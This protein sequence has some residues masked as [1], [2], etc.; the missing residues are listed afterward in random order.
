MVGEDGD[1]D[2]VVSEDSPPAPHLGSLVAVEEGAPPTEVPFQTGDSGLR[3]GAPLDQAGEPAASL[4]GGS[5]RAG[6]AFAG[7]GH[8]LHSENDQRGIHGSLAI[9]PIGG[10][11]FGRLAE[12][13]G[14]PAD[15]GDEH[16]DV[17]RVADH[18]L[19]INHDPIR[20][21]DHLGLVAELDRAA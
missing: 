10:D 15:G 13:S 12:T 20:V 21:V 2:R 3:A 16:R 18:D 8:H 6:L 19:M 9:T 1:L 14:D 17:G 11:R 4:H 5:R 7:D